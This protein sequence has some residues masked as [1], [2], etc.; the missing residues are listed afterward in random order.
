MAY[1]PEVV[2]SKPTAG[3][4]HFTC[5]KETSRYRTNNI[6]FY[7]GGAG[8]ARWAHNSEDIGSKPIS[9]I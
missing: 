6:L 7:R 1:N 9:G 5:F 2:G 4:S 3:N 8:A